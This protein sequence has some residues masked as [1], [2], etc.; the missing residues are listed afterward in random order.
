[1]LVSLASWEVGKLETK[2][3]RKVGILETRAIRKLGIW[4]LESLNVR[5]LGIS[6]S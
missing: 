6:G 1:M 3:R 5:I 2:G 4:Q